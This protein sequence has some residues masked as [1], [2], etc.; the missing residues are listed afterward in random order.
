MTQQ[1]QLPKLKSHNVTKILKLTKDICD[2]LS[3]LSFLGPKLEPENLQM[4]V[5]AVCDKLPKTI[6]RKTVFDSSTY[7]GTVEITQQELKRYAWRLAGNLDKLIAGEPATPWLRQTELEWMPLQ[8]VDWQILRNF[9]GAIVC[10]YTFRILGG[11]ATSELVT[12]RL[13][14]RACIGFSSELG[15][16]KKSRKP[17]AGR[18][19]FNDFADLFGMRLYGLFDPKLSIT[20]PQF[21]HMGCSGSFK[22][23]NRE[24]LKKRAR[25]GFVCPKNFTHMCSKC[26]VG[27]DHCVAATHAK[28]HRSKMCDTCK[29]TTW[30]DL[31]Q[32]VDMCISCATKARLRS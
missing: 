27:A 32:S 10:N 15:F 30:F 12:K 28:T 25:I 7:L 17:K 23:Y 31:S 6:M 1:N 8:I 22:T 9:K 2:D 4:F 16:S 3:V 26:P 19:C 14:R 29:Q 11:S 21:W 20:S 24:L 13:S 5:D 18:I